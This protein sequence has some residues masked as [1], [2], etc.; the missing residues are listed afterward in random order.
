MFLKIKQHIT[1]KRLFCSLALLGLIVFNVVNL[2]SA[3]TVTEGYGADEV[4]QRGMIVGAKQ[5][6]PTK[7]EP[8]SVDQ[9]DRMMGVVVDAN[10]SPI[11]IS[12]EAE[13]VFVSSVGQYD[14]LVS[15][16]NG[17][18]KQGDYI[19]ASSLNG[20]GMLATYKEGDVLGRAITGFDGNGNIVSQD[21][22]KDN[23]GVTQNVNIG[24]IKVDIG[25]SKNPKARSDAASPEWLGK[26]GQA[27]AGQSVSPAKVYLGAGLF[28]IGAFIAGTILYSGIRSSL[29]SV[30]R[31]PLSKKSIMKGLLQVIF[32]SLIVFIISVFGVYLLLRV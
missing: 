25:V 12:G 30:G 16:Q 1:F 22:L 14:V 23:K 19:T 26:L 28:V 11:T 2:T 18:I 24:R 15:N 31:N 9:L 21:S 29:I 27:I 3:Q 32:T 17:E 20:I 7:V 13:K 5:D 4:L 10:E 8:I 6:D